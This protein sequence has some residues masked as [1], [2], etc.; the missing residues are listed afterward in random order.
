MAQYALSGL[1]TS[2][3]TLLLGLF[4]LY[5]NP[6]APRNRIFCLF[7]LSIAAWSGAL[8]IHTIAQNQIQAMIW[9]RILHAFSILIAVFFLHLTYTLCGIVKQRKRLLVVAYIV[10]LITFVL[11]LSPWLV[12]AR[13]LANF[14]FIVA[15]HQNL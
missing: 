10:V 1:L 11:D 15:V 2:L 8:F 7:S 3:A 14:G 12:G 4:V 6:K 5:K 9:A 13:H